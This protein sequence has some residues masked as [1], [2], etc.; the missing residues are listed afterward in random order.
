MWEIYQAPTGS[1]FAQQKTSIKVRVSLN[2]RSAI[3]R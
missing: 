2:A 3:A 1:V